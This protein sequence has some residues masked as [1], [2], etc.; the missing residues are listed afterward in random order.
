[1]RSRL[2]QA[3][4]LVIF[5]LATG[6]LMSERILSFVRG[7]LPERNDVPPHRT[8]TYDGWQT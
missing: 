1:M 7:I 4:F 8:L 5:G 2:I 3:V 6:Y